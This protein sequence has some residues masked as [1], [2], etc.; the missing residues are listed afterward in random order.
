MDANGFDVVGVR[1]EGLVAG[2]V[3]RVTMTGATCGE[4]MIEFAPQSVMPATAPVFVVI[5]LL[6]ERREIFVMVLGSVGGIITREDVAKPPVRMWLFGAVT[7]LEMAFNRLLE[8]RFPDD[9]WKDEISEARI[10]KAQALQTERARTGETVPLIE[11]LYFS[12]KATILFKKPEIRELFGIPSR[13]RARK[14]T[15]DLKRLRDN[16]AHSGDILTHGWE[17]LVRIS[18]VV[19]LLPQLISMA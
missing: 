4:S 18:G 5:Q 3:T 1:R 6:D 14:V 17:T 19:D 8:S 15:A 12:D 16:L 2:Y 11:C 9:S 13:A 10:A 7:M